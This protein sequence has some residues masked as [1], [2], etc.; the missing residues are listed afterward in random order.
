EHAMRNCYSSG[1]LLPE[2]V[3]G[4][5]FNGDGKLD[6]AVAN[7]NCLTVE[8]DIVCRT[9][10]VSVLLGNG[11]GTFQAAVHYSTL[12]DHAFTVADGDRDRKPDLAVP[13]SQSL[14][15][16]LNIAAG[17]HHS[18]STAVASSM[19]PINLHQTVTFTA[20]VTSTTDGMPG[21]SITFSDGGHA[22][23]SV[24]IA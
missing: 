10:S 19:N 4:G 16:L 1:G 3:L 23:A 14:T 11:N 15:I 8:L 17:F 13:T 22:L 6:L 18:T 24:S 2:V 5:D 7:S 9:G 21:G 12:D 20:T